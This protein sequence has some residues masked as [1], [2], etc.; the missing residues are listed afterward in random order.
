[1]GV[2]GNFETLDTW[3]KRLQQA[4]IRMAQA[5]AQGSAPKLTTLARAAYDGGRNVY[6]ESRQPGAGGKRLTLKRTGATYGTVRFVA[7]GTITR[8]VLG[9][10]Y[11]RFLIGKYGILPSGR[12]VLPYDW[13]QAIGNVVK[14]QTV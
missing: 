5:V 9:T 6:G 2:K 12:G 13:G 4:P 1:M 8:C 3:R 11:A 7:V 14:E 10:D